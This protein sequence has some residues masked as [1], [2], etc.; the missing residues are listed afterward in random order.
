MKA[1]LITPDQQ[2][3]EAIDVNNLDEIRQIIGYDTLESDAIGSD[4]DKLFFDEECFLRGTSGRFQVDSLIPVSG[5]GVVVGASAD[6]TDLQD[7]SISIDN[8][9][10]RTKYL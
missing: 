10:A 4:G 6:N 3:I 2:I 9:T 1:L 5:K 8:L 7:V